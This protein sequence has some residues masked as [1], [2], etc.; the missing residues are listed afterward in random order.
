MEIGEEKQLLTAEQVGWL[1][2]SDEDIASELQLDAGAEDAR[3]ILYAGKS[4]DEPIVSQGRFIA[5]NADQI[6]K[7]YQ[8]F[9]YGK[10]NHIAAS[11]KQQN[12]LLIRID[13]KENK[14]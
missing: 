7:L 1:N 10:M 13:L 3:L 12:T 5:D 4:Q 11:P 6:Q 14:N 9:R 2:Q 8:D